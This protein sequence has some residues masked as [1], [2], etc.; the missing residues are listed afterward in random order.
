MGDKSFL[1]DMCSSS[2]VEE[3][4]CRDS[5]RCSRVLTGGPRFTQRGTEH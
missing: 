4:E 3:K 2:Q 5:I 1:T